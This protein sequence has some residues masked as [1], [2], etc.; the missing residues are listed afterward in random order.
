MHKRLFAGVVVALVLG[1]SARSGAADKPV[2]GA[3]GL[4]TQH[5]SRTVRPG[6]DFYR[7]VNEGWLKTA[8]PPP[9]LPYANAFVDAYLRT[10]GQL[11]SLIDRILSAKADPGSD[12]DKIATLYRSYVDMD[13]RNALG[14]APLAP[15]LDEVRAIRDHADAAAVMGRPLAKSPMNAAVTVDSRNP[16]RY[17]VVLAQ[18]GLGLPGR[19]YYL[20]AQEP[21]AGHRQAYLAHIAEIFRRAGMEGGPAKAQAILDL[22]TKLA[23]VQW[24][25]A[26]TRDPVKTYRAMTLPELEA[27][28]PGFAWTRFWA[29]TG[30]GVPDRVV[31]QTDSA[32]QKSAAIVAAADIETLRAY[33]A[34]HYIDDLSPLLSAE[35]SDLNFAFYGNRLGGIA[36]QQSLANRAQAHIAGGFGEV[37]GRAY[38]R[39]FFPAAYREQMD[40]MVGHLRTAFR[41]R[42]E[43]NAWMDEPTRK[44]AIVKLDAIVSHIGYPDRYRD[45]SS[46]TFTAGDLVANQKALVRFFV[47]DSVARLGEP[48]RDWQWGYP[49]TEINAGYSPSMNSITF[50]A[51]ILQSP[52]F[53]PAADAAVNYGSIGAVIGHELGHAFDDQGSQSDE[54]GALRNW[55]TP[56]ARGEFEKRAAVLVAQFDGFTA[57]PGLNVNGKLTLG[58]NIGDL[59]GLTIGLD[60]YRA[61][62]AEQNGGQAPVIDGFTGEQRYFLAWAQ[63][64]RDFTTPDTLRRN[65]LTDPHSPSEF[66]VN[67]PL[68]NM[69]AWYAAFGVK[70][71]DALYLAP[72]KRT[73]IW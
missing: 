33:L 23:Q 70:E 8:A 40:R 9:G 64:W 44:A 72:E 5:M 39:Q 31:V 10:Q 11:Q 68:R 66:R 24:S 58:E 30:L 73:R 19:D 14:L 71:G 29:S 12:E 62:V 26:E 63:L 16:R 60:A 51:G 67:G 65:V 25:P 18:G 13:R 50:P 69:D 28:A 4:E 22:E 3:W 53:D 7:Y 34:F 6:D 27:Y 17:V 59:G 37:L 35:W 1:F 56:A 15:D 47:A 38:A 52:F 43:G 21:Y 48:R 32:I 2:L 55:W 54:T 46:L 49:A 61:H 36:Q 42:L 57:L 45:W 41:K 20:E